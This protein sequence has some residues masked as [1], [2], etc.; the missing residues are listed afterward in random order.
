MIH[1]LALI[2]LVF[3][4]LYP[5]VTAG[6][7]IAGGLLF[8]LLDERYD[9]S[10]PP[11][12]WPGV[13]VL[14]PAYNEAAVVGRC[15]SAALAVDYPNLEVLVLD[16]GSTDATGAAAAAA[17]EDDQRL[18]VVRDPVNRGKAERLN[19]G[20]RRASHELVAV[21]DAD[22]HLRPL[23]QRREAATSHE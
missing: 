17:G 4:S 19:L 2:L 15:V 11:E 7:W 8:R 16:D 6:L 22:T 3:V 18:Q 9:G 23:H 20:F 13:T 10:A 14:I 1:I 5:I 12:G 21:C